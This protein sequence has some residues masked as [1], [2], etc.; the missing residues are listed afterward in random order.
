M[1]GVARPRSRGR[2]APAASAASR[3]RRPEALGAEDAPQRPRPERRRRMRLLDEKAEPLE[4]VREA[5]VRQQ[6]H[7]AAA[8]GELVDAADRTPFFCGSLP[9]ATAAHT[10]S[11]DV[12]CS[13]ARW[14]TA[15]ASRIRPKF[16]SR[17]SAVALVIRSS[18]AASIA[19]T[20]TRAAA[21]GRV[22][23]TARRS[24]APRAAATR[25][26][27]AGR[28]QRRDRRDRDEREQ[29][30]PD[31][32]RLRCPAAQ[33]GKQQTQP[34][35]RGERRR[36]RDQRRRGLRIR[37]PA[38]TCRRCATSA[39]RRRRPPR[40]QATQHVDADPRRREHF[41]REQLPHDEQDVEDHGQVHGVVE[42]DRREQRR[43]ARGCSGSVG[44]R[45]RTSAIT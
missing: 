26:G 7:G 14:R 37:A 21:S 2:P 8:A 19:I 25:R 43:Q 13:V 1:I 28:E 34:G 20:V 42:P 17:P 15:P 22:D 10:A 5:V 31:A 18:D 23:R 4:A 45:C 38:R 33:H 40:Q 24:A 39:P 29:R 9:V 36:A 16:G 44:F 6:L 35:G 12:G 30:G 3:R 11:A 32:A 41:A 27:R